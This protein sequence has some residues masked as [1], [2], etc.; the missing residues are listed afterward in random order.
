MQEHKTRLSNVEMCKEGLLC[1]LNAIKVP[2]NGLL[3]RATIEEQ[4]YWVAFKAFLTDITLC[5]SNVGCG[6][7]CKWDFLFIFFSFLLQT[8]K[9]SATPSVKL[10]AELVSKDICY[11]LHMFP[12]YPIS[13]SSLFWNT[14]L[15]QQYIKNHHSIFYTKSV[16]IATTTKSLKNVDKDIC[17][18]SNNLFIYVTLW[19]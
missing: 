12:F 16:F 13:V 11:Y 10:S 15:N 1:L 4:Q 2:R 19:I 3:L 9:L 6:V 14:N 7:P 5:C 8:F 18:L 17:F